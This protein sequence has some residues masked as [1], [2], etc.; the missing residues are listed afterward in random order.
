MGWFPCS[1]CCGDT[2]PTCANCNTGSG[3]LAVSVTVSGVANNT[4]VYCSNWNGTFVLSP[5]FFA[6]RYSTCANISSPY[7]GSLSGFATSI[8]VELTIN[9]TSL[10]IIFEP[11]IACNPFLF[12][13]TRTTWI[14]NSFSGD[15]SPGTTYTPSLVGLPTATFCDFTS[16]SMTVIF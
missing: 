13:S 1:D 6:C 7:C 16:A 12:N 3:P 9:P 15:C 4:C 8:Y 2:G 14:D 5:G 11:M 10:D